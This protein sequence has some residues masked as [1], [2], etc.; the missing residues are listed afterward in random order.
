M[1]VLSR[2]ALVYSF[3]FH[4]MVL[5]IPAELMDAGRKLKKSGTVRG[6]W[7]CLLLVICREL[8]MIN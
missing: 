8:V 6:F 1:K 5:E 4:Y 2:K 3:A 7:Q